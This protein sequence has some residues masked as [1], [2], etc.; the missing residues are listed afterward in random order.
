[1]NNSNP[2][3]AGPLDLRAELRCR[4]IRRF[5]GSSFDCSLHHSILSYKLEMV[6]QRNFFTSSSLE[7]HPLVIPQHIAST[8]IRT[9]LQGMIM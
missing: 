9:R 1:M 8:K 5:H 6:S 4:R 2:D 7:P 3:D